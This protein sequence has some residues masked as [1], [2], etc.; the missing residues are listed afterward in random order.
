MPA[1]TIVNSIELRHPAT[2]TIT[3]APGRKLTRADELEPVGCK[4]GALGLLELLLDLAHLGD[5]EGEPINVGANVALLRPATGWHCTH[6]D[7]PLA[8]GLP[9][10]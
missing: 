9:R 3:T 6:Y 8:P 2:P 7:A 1:D 5:S 4:R 10:G